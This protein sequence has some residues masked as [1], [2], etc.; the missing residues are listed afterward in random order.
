MLKLNPTISR[1]LNDR[2]NSAGNTASV[3]FIDRGKDSPYPAGIP[4]ALA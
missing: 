3:C 2:L 1:K 4:D